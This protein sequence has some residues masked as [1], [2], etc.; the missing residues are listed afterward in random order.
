MNNINCE[1]IALSDIIEANKKILFGI[2]I[3]INLLPSLI[4]YLF[5]YTIFKMITYLAV[6]NIFLICI[7]IFII[8]IGGTQYKVTIPQENIPINWQDRLFELTKN[9]GILL[10]EKEYG[11]I[12]IKKIRKGFTKMISL[13][14]IQTEKDSSEH[15]LILNIRIYSRNRTLMNEL[16]KSIKTSLKNHNE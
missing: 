16:M 14:M 7:V 6:G 15:Y 11:T 9:A 4:M 10:K 3:G 13:G 5:S 12:D 1:K 8:A 2:L